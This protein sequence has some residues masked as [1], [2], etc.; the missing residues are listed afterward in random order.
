MRGLSAALG[1][2][3]TIWKS[4]RL[5]AECRAAS[6]AYGS[7]PSSISPPAVGFSRQT[8]ARPE[9][10]LP[11][12]DSPM[13]P[14]VSPAR[15]GEAHAVDRLHRLGPARASKNGRAGRSPRR[16][17]SC[18][19]ARHGEL[20][21][22]DAARTAVVRHSSSAC[23][24]SQAAMPCAQ[25][26]GSG[27]RPACRPATARGPDRG[28]HR[29]ARAEPRDRAQQARR[30]GMARPRRTAPS[31]PARPRPPRPRTSSACACRSRR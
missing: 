19:R 9:V 8:T 24:A 22:A 20:G 18:D 26:G 4:R 29:L 17:C 28:Q 10:D 30:I 3:K 16:C 13:T 14:K 21:L 23:V 25:R 15:I 11:E 27:S 31:R 12:P 6:S 7:V 5:P 1:S 2:W